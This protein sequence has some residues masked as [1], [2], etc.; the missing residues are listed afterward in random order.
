VNAHTAIPHGTQEDLTAYSYTLA[1]N[2]A[3][4][5]GAVIR[6]GTGEGGLPIGIQI[7]ARPFREDH[8]LAVAGWLEQKLG[9]FPR[10][11]VWAG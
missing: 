9:E 3:G 11:A 4:W 1:F 7:L 5:P 8:C 2:L 10:P 6:G